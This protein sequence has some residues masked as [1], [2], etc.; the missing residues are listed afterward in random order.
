MDTALAYTDLTTE[1]SKI[2]NRS[3][4]CFFIPFTSVCYDRDTEGVTVKFCLGLHCNLIHGLR[5]KNTLVLRAHFVTK[6]TITAQWGLKPPSI[7]HRRSGCS[8][9]TPQDFSLHVGLMPFELHL[10]IAST[11]RR[12]QCT[13]WH[14]G[15]AT[16]KYHSR[17]RK[18]ESVCRRQTERCGC[19]SI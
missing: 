6:P 7:G 1:Y 18:R 15:L 17:E 11:T 2:G 12:Q 14:L 5:Y 9:R 13:H 16:L 3:M 4:R 10:Q 8:R 19:V